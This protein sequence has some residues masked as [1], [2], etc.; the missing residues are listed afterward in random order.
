MVA[1]ASFRLPPGLPD[2]FAEK[3]TD[4]SPPVLLG[5][6]QD[7]S[8][9]T[10]AS[11]DFQLVADLDREAVLLPSGL[12]G[13]RTL[14]LAAGSVQAY[15]DLGKVS[16]SGVSV[17]LDGHTFQANGPHAPAPPAKADPRIN[18]R[19]AYQVR[20][21]GSTEYRLYTDV[22][23]PATGH[24]L[25]TDADGVRPE[26]GAAGEL[27][28]ARDRAAPLL[29]AA[30]APLDRVPLLEGPDAETGRAACTWTRRTRPRMRS[31]G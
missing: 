6:I 24:E 26:D 19:R 30:G 18:A 15:G 16:G 10:A 4:R 22:T 21:A 3:T 7:M 31:T 8:S 29:Q 5:S 23:D 9:C 1:S 2:P 12:L 25:G 11:G 13:G 20:V 17:Q 27:V 14:Y 28:A